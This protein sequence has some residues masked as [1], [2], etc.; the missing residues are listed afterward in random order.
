MTVQ[1]EDLDNVLAH[2]GVKGMKWGVRRG[3]SDGSSGP[4]RSERRQ[5]KK[6]AKADEKFEKNASSAK[7][8]M[9]IYNGAAKR[10][11]EYHIER[12]NS[13]PE[14]K[15]VK[16]GT[17]QYDKYVKEYEETLV[18]ELDA[19]AS[20][21]GTNASGTKKLTVKTNEDGSGWDVHVVDTD[22]VKH[23][24]EATGWTIEAKKDRNG[25]ILSVKFVKKELTHEDLTM[26]VEAFL[27][28]YGVKGMK[29]GKRKS[30]STA[31]VEVTA[32][33]KPGRR[34]RTTGGENQPAS[35]D[36]IRA[37]KLQRQA[38]KSTTD[39]LSTPELQALVQRMNLEKQYAQL[40][41]VPPNKAAMKLVAG[42]LVNS[43]KQQMQQVVNTQVSGLVG[44]SL[45][46]K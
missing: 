12:I 8:T 39:S 34:V 26:D 18:K 30:R 33:T 19:Q 9:A 15:D 11:N 23:A 7:T 28:H 27:L 42:V 1:V 2:F 17:K 22:K 43:G 46:K 25:R 31:P 29:W 38:R 40:A 37:A 3:D 45:K 4:S 35:E 20:A 44:D 24:D 14:Y 21:M 41:P 10:M 32:T 36:A 16:V 5:E 6:I 13:K